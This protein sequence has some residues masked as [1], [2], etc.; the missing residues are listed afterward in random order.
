MP[1]RG[2]PGA[3]EG[4]DDNQNITMLPQDTFIR[5]L[6]AGDPAQSKTPSSKPKDDTN[7]LYNYGQRNTTCSSSMTHPEATGYTATPS[8]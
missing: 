5:V 1:Y 6:E 7:S 2:P 4:K 3:D 8:G